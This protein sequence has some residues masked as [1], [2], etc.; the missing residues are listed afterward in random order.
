MGQENMNTSKNVAREIWLNYFN[1]VLFRKGLI[2]ETTKRKMQ[3]R[4]LKECRRRD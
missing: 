4:I 1:E 3:E 2:N